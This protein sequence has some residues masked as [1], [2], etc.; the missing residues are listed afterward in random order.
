MSDHTDHSI[1][2]LYSDNDK[3]LEAVPVASG[4][5]DS[6]GI[7]LFAPANGDQS[8]ECFPSFSSPPSR[9]RSRGVGGACPNPNESGVEALTLEEQ[10]E[11][12]WCSKTALA[13][14][15]NIPVC[16][17]DGRETMDSIRL[18]DPSELPLY[19]PMIALPGTIT[20]TECYLS[21]SSSPRRN[22]SVPFIHNFNISII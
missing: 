7:N 18:A 21:M 3:N 17:S 19:E 9:V 20:L 8:D 10:I 13:G 6:A 2:N 11:R 1:D 4:S 22:V 5:L 16:K 14:F 12:L 15:A